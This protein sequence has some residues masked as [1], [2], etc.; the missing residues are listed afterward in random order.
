M[1]GDKSFMLPQI[2]LSKFF[3]SK[4]LFIFQSLLDLHRLYSN[5]FSPLHSN[6][7][8]VGSSLPLTVNCC[9]NLNLFEIV[10]V[11]V[12]P[13]CRSPPFTQGAFIFQ[14]F[15][16]RRNFCDETFFVTI[17][18]R[19]VSRK[20]LCPLSHP[21]LCSLL[22]CGEK[23]CVLEANPQQQVWPRC[24]E[25]HLQCAIMCTMCIALCTRF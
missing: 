22:N 5:I 8:R 7:N 3:S 23:Q 20:S 11:Y 14:T 6:I 18:P 16:R 15:S 13:V 1:G 24:A 17:I 21:H 19:V 12:F 10:P 25:Y 4:N 2:S 9:I